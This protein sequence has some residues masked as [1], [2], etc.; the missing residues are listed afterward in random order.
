[1]DLNTFAYDLYDT[2]LS[3]FVR[4]TDGLI[5]TVQSLHILG[6]AV[7]VGSTLVMELRFAGVLAVD[8]DRQMVV[9]RHLPWLWGALLVLALTGLTMTIGEP[10]RVLTNSVFLYKM[11]VVLGAFV[12]TLL[13][14]YPLLR[15][16]EGSGV[17][18]RVAL[19]RPLAWLLIL[20]WI[21]VIFCGRWI[22]YAL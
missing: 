15:S 3:A 21:T 16:A 13:F 22:A 2:R 10:Y 4:L 18:G 5:P 6:V 12:L 14:R 8:E 7:L 20:A 11:A 17:L 1:M 19:A 9:R